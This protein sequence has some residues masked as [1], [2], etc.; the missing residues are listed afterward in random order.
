MD[1]S[2]FLKEA[3]NV[4]TT[5]M[6]KEVNLL[7]NQSKTNF[8]SL[9]L[10][11]SLPIE[12]VIQQSDSVPFGKK[13]SLPEISDIFTS[14]VYAS[15]T[16]VVKFIFLYN[17]EKH[18]K[19][20]MKVLHKNPTFFAFHYVKQL[21]HVLRNHYTTSHTSF[22]LRNTNHSSPYEAIKMANDIAVNNSLRIIFQG[23]KLSQ[24]WKHIEA[25]I[26]ID[27]NICEDTEVQ[28]LKRITGSANR[29]KSTPYSEGAT[30]ITF[31][32]TDNEDKYSL[33]SGTTPATNDVLSTENDS[34]LSNLATRVY[35]AIRTAA[36]SSGGPGCT[37][38]T[39]QFE[40]VET[41]TSWFDKVKA[42]F[43]KTVHYKTE[44]FN[45]SWSGI[46]NTYR[47]LYKAPITTYKQTKVELILSVD[48]SGSMSELDLQKLLFLLEDNSRKIAKCTVIVHTG[49]V[50]KVFDLESKDDHDITESENWKFMQTR[51]SNGGTSHE[52]VFQYIQEMNITNPDDIIYISLSDNYSDIEPTINNFPIMRKLTKYWLAPIGSRPVD[53]HECGG[54]N[55]TMN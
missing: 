20:I 9:G 26:N 53:E 30:L 15:D 17:N 41:D 19:H 46:D 39:G 52:P 24:K 22:M 2:L 32:P 29:A 50:D 31:G 16:T 13:L 6:V 48:Q 51:L 3:E 49:T 47:H 36:K 55:I 25:V 1:K 14:V 23:S 33:I 44:H 45:Q 12:F 7:L 28:I 37:Q 54:I 21:Q 18:L 42:S 27:D 40:A 35:D 10:F 5:E 4:I 38:M 34:G 11:L 43:E 8:L